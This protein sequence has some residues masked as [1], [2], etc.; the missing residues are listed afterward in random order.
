VEPAVAEGREVSHQVA[1]STCLVS[2]FLRPMLAYFGH[3]S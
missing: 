1:A 2:V 3:L